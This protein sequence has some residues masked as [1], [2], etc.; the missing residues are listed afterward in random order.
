MAIRAPDGAKK[1]R[2]SF[3]ISCVL[4]Q[5]MEQQIRIEIRRSIMFFPQHFGH[6]KLW[7]L[8]MLLVSL[9]LDLEAKFNII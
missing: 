3:T 2:K 6:V 8:W 1:K 9:V 7:K 5:I 4:N